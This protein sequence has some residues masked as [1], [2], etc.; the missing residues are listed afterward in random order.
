ME[1]AHLSSDLNA[2]GRRPR[3][4]IVAH[5][6][7]GA[8]NGGCSG[9][10]GGVEY[11]TAMTARWLAANRFDVTL[12]VW[13]EGQPSD[14]HVDGVRVLS[15]CRADEGLPGL[16]F[17]HPR[18]TSLARALR[19]ADADLYY[20]NCGEYVTGQV[21]SWCRSHRRR[22]VFSVASDPECD[23]R[24]PAMRSLRER[25]LY[26]YGLRHADRIIVQT[27]RQQTMLREGFG[28][29]S[30][31]LPMPCAGPMEG[32]ARPAAVETPARFVWVGRIS[33]EKDPDRFLA[34]ARALPQ[35]RFD[36]AGPAP[37]DWARE[38]VARAGP[39]VRILGRVPR[40]EMSTVYAGATA[41][42][43]TSVFEGFPNTFLESWSHGVPVITTVDPDGLVESLG[44]GAA[45]QETADLIGAAERLAQHGADWDRAAARA[46]EYYDRHHRPDRALAR[47]GDE[48]L[49]VCGCPPAAAGR[50]TAGPLMEEAGCR[51]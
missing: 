37:T 7:W 51:R 21:A 22:F 27:R 29:E 39:N 8:I 6:A 25:V 38:V 3:V 18:W 31:V 47:F 4:C 40:S 44:L 12:V 46:R 16:R 17:V 49:D 14:T 20:Q 42:V 33:P 35:F 41:L 45:S 30:V 15:L 28:L 10:A 2:G 13:N 26:R 36:L 50:T 43:C 5:M 24:L 9:H 1:A 48:F 32:E 11:Q 34:I 19:T 23:P